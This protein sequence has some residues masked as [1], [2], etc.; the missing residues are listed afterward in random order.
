MTATAWLWAPVLAP[1][2]CVDGV[3]GTALP[4]GDEFPA[5]AS[6]CAPVVVA[7]DGCIETD[8]ADCRMDNAF[9]V[10]GVEES[11]LAEASLGAKL[12]AGVPFGAE[13]AVDCSSGAVVPCLEADAIWELAFGTTA[14]V[15]DAPAGAE[16][17]VGVGVG[18][19]WVELGRACEA[20]VAE[21]V[22]SEDVDE[23]DTVVTPITV[24]CV[25]A[26]GGSYTPKIAGMQLSH[27]LCMADI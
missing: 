17:V 13:E 8:S 4:E 15:A 26:F 2:A 14:G 12:S 7:A 22:G 9:V 16:V 11:A 6:L 25:S 10:V 1:L 21:T 18:A 3:A 23:A 24:V 20:A 27:S 5:W 19:F